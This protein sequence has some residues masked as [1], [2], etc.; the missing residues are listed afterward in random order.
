MSVPAAFIGVILIWSTTPLAIKWSSEGGGFLF[1]VTARMLLG[2]ALCLALIRVLR[3]D[4]PWH[5][6]ARR[7]YL[8]AGLGIYGAMITVYWGAQYIPSGLI[9]VLYGLTP[10]MTGVLAAVFL[11]ESGVKPGKFSG[12][13]AGVAGLVVIF[14]VGVRTDAFAVLG[15]AAVLLS[16]FL[17][18]A[19][20]VWIKRIG[21]EMP[22]MAVTGGGLLVAAPLYLT[23]WILVDGSLPRALPIRA[24]LSIGYLG[25]VGSVLG[26][27]LYYYAL[28]HLA[29]GRIAL[30]TLITP[31]TALLLGSFL[32]GEHVG[33]QVW[34]G[35]ALI[36]AG[37]VLHQ[38]SDRPWK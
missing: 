3:V 4:M 18:A 33:M 10:L 27:I 14:G 31:I 29:V 34:M 7:T 38:W 1:G 17:H 20:A 23:T 24:M 25:T 11:G 37:L 12:M 32:N 9:S 2:A 21:A 8:A 30:I 26:F 6:N 28:K 5:K 15:M 13:V 35:T 19:S 16:V 36:M 22:A